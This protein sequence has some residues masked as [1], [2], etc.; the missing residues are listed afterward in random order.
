MSSNLNILFI[1]SQFAPHLI[2]SNCCL[3]RR[4]W[5]YLAQFWKQTLPFG[6]LHVHL[7][8]VVP[9]G[10]PVRTDTLSYLFIRYH[11]ICGY[12]VKGNQKTLPVPFRTVWRLYIVTGTFFFKIKVFHGHCVHLR[13][14]SVVHPV[15]GTAGCTVYTVRYCVLWVC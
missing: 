2:Y 15:I 6:W 7:S 3:L 12:L 11:S 9:Y 4:F 10:I 14:V 1:L 8:R 13:S 5:G